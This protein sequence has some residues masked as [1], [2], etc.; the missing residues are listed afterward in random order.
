M[1]RLAKIGL[2]NNKTGGFILQDIKTYYKAT[3]I[4][5]EKRQANETK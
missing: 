4:K 2:K 5:A 3:V 1:P